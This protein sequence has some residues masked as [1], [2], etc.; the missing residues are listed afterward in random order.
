MLLKIKEIIEKWDPLDYFPQN[1]YGIESFEILK[2]IQSSKTISIEL[3]SDFITQVLIKEYDPDK[4]FNKNDEEQL[5][6]SRQIYNLVNNSKE[7]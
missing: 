4:R 3:I 5:E 6:I 2:R 1:I 7:N